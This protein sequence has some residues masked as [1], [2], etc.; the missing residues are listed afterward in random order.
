VVSSRGWG[1]R[2]GLPDVGW[3]GEADSLEGKAD[4]AVLM[5]R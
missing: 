4:I 2:L 3:Q 5:K 1:D